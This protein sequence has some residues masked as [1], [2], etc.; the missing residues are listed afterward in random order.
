MTWQALAGLHLEIL[1]GDRHGLRDVLL[2]FRRFLHLLFGRIQRDR[3]CLPAPLGLDVRRQGCCARGDHQPDEY[4]DQ[5]CSS[6]AAHATRRAGIVADLTGH[7]RIIRATS[8]PF[9]ETRAVDVTAP[10]PPV[11][12][13]A[14]DDIGQ[15]AIGACAPSDP[16]LVPA[17]HHRLPR[18]RQRR[19]RQAA[20]ADDL[21][22]SETIY[23]LG[24]GIFFIGYFL[25]EVPSNLI[26][27]RVGAR[28]WIARIMIT[29][30]VVSAAIMFVTTPTMFY[31][32]ALSARRG[33]GRLL[34]RHHPVSDLLVSRRTAR[35]A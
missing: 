3:R 21:K 19:L 25:F 16:L 31:F 12:A 14:P 35:R 26:L 27:Q 18:P 28:V 29:W 6:C 33:R 22:F 24:A 13:G 8:V 11:R 20:D 10:P 7:A 17:L 15:R 4:S 5:H 32:D 1:A 23:G 9:D 34:S 2:R 30:G